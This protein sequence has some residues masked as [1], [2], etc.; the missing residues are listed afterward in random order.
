MTR[1]GAL[2]VLAVTA[3]SQAVACRRAADKPLSAEGALRHATAPR[4]TRFAWW[5]ER[6]A[7]KIAERDAFVAAGASPPVVFI[8]D[9]ITERWEREG[10]AVWRERF[11]PLGAW[12][13]GYSSDGTAQVL[14]R[15]G[16]PAEGEAPDAAQAH[17][18]T[19]GLAPDWFVLLVGTNNT[20]RYRGHPVATAAGVRAVVERLLATAAP[21]RVLLLGLTP[22]GPSPD[23]PLRR[24]NEAVNERLQALADRERV[25]FLDAGE[26]LLDADGHLPP[27]V[28]PDGLHLS[29]DGYRRLAEAIE[30]VLQ[31]LTA[32]AEEP[33]HGR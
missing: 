2:R 29:E 18:E 27:A 4:P 12:N 3:A 16:A 1:R 11:A 21:T 19:A 33:T 17:N 8:G 6:H 31:G 15:L 14:W 10:A 5:R 28:A 25:V 32:P 30:P 22:R 13:L 20:A 9:S 24:V 7:A 26:T 23:D